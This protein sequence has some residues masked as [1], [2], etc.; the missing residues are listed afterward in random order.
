MQLHDLKPKSRATKKRIGRGGAHGK[1]SGRGHKG[2]KAR[3]GGTPR[4]QIRDAIKKIPKLRGYRNK[5]IGNKAVAV[6]LASV[7]RVAGKGDIVSPQFLVAQG[8]VR[9]SG[10]QNPKVKILG[11]GDIK[12]AV[13]IVRCEVSDTAREKI[14]AAGGEIKS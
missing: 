5:P 11:G 7:A 4:P 14:E 6:N 3:A 10:A 8:I 12:V 9:K 2:Q 1:Q 13:S